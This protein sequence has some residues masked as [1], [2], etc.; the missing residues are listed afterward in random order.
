MPVKPIG[1]GKLK[2]NETPIA[3][4]VTPVYAD[5]LL[6][7]GRQRKNEDEGQFRKFMEIV[8]NLRVT[9]PFLEIITHIP[10]YA[11]T[12]KDIVVRKQSYPKVETVAL[13][14]ECSALLQSQPPPKLKDLGSFSIP[15]TV[16]ALEIDNALCDL[17]ASASVLPIYS[18]CQKTGLGGLKC[19]DMTLQMADRSVKRPLGVLEDVPVKGDFCQNRTIQPPFSSSSILILVSS[20]NQVFWKSSLSLRKKWWTSTVRGF[21]ATVRGL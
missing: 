13:I 11:K 17:G 16:G 9:V 5:I 12:M 3:E 7:P 2:T 18:V 20:V 4:V 10:I 15:C 1:T 21:N 14:G 8:K 19:T 6:F